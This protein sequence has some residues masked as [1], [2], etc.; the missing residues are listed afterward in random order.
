[1][2][3][4]HVFDVSEQTFEKEVLEASRQTLV[5]VDFW[6]E[7]CGPCKTLGPQLET[8][9]EEY[10]GA[11]RLAKVDVDQH[12]R[13]SMMFGV[14]SIPTVFALYQGQPVDSFQ[15]ALPL[16]EL[17]RFI[18]GLLER[19]G[20]SP[21]EAD[22][23]PEDPKEALAWWMA[24]L[25]ATEADTEARLQVGRLHIAAGDVESGRAHLQKI[26]ATDPEYNAAHAALATLDLAS[27]V[28]DAGGEE[29][30]RARLAD[31]PNDP[32]ARYLMACVEASAG[33]YVAA[34]TEFVALVGAAPAEV[35]DDAKKAAAIVFEAAGRDDPDVEQLRRRL[36]RLLF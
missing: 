3:S 18:D 9:A 13:L 4:A 25:E 22:T 30:V 29:A 6:A 21:P 11:F 20:I 15:G 5:L 17:R 33:R 19:L 34:L 12:Q 35:A 28:G 26:A 32:R 2:A 36:A 8:L 23:P 16:T 1:M 7:W 10:R 24:R 14:Q 31:D 27:A